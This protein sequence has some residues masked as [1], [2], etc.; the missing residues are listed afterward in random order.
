MNGRPDQQT[1]DFDLNELEL[2]ALDAAWEKLSQDNDRSELQSET[3][4][5][6]APEIPDHRQPNRQ[7][8][9]G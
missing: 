3:G 4:M 7:E 6:H 5:N 8:L 9:S 2:E 1:E